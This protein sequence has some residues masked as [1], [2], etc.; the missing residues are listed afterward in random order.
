MPESDSEGEQYV[1]HLMAQSDMAKCQAEEG[2]LP[3]KADEIFL[4]KIGRAS[5][6]ERV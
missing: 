2:R 6:R 1:V 3:E 5:C 4:D